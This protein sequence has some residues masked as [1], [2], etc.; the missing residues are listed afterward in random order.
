MN[1]II[2]TILV[3]IVHYVID[4]MKSVPLNINLKRKSHLP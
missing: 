1:L 3:E 4:F 2:N